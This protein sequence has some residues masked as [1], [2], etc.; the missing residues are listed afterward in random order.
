MYTEQEL[1]PHHPG[2]AWHEGNLK[3]RQ[4]SFRLLLDRFSGFTS[5]LMD[6]GKDL[7]TVLNERSCPPPV[8]IPKH[9]PG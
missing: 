4:G 5:G 9:S 6:V 8:V 1:M 7:E 2:S 3:Y